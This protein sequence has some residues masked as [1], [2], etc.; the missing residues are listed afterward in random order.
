VQHVSSEQ[1]TLKNA[2]LWDAKPCSFVKSNV[3]EEF[4]ASINRVER[5]RKLGTLAVN[6]NSQIIYNFLALQ[7]QFQTQDDCDHVLVD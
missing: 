3:S 4:I 7:L 1:T 6:S 2:V 5:I